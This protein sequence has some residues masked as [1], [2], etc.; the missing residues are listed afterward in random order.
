[1]SEG[2]PNVFDAILALL[3]PFVPVLPSCRPHRRHGYK[4]PEVSASFPRAVD[5]PSAR[6]IDGDHRRAGMAGALP[7]RFR[8]SFEN[9][10]NTCVFPMRALLQN[11]FGVGMS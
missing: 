8:G 6:S 4:R 1:M 2:A 11:R 9:A 10:D 3:V 7:T 5:V